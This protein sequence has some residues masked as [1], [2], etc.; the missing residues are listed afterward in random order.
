MGF[1]LQTEVV[2]TISGCIE[3]WTRAGWTNETGG[4]V[5]AY[6]KKAR[7]QSLSF[8]GGI[9][10]HC[11]NGEIIGSMFVW[12]LFIQPSENLGYDDVGSDWSS[13]RWHGKKHM[14]CLTSNHLS[15]NWHQLWMVIKNKNGELFHFFLSHF[16]SVTFCCHC[17]VMTY[18][19]TLNT[20]DHPRFY[21][22]RYLSEHRN[23]NVLRSCSRVTWNRS[24]L[25][26]RCWGC[27]LSFE[28]FCRRTTC[29]LLHHFG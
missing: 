19:M 7:E 20:L 23:Y 4:P 6:D 8:R 25:A 11:D 27:F 21:Q 10:Q 15:S 16:L 22:L 12:L 1:L 24:P 26:A 28:V 9:P 18:K 13:L 29:A 3:H 5:E 17:H 14:I 2:Y